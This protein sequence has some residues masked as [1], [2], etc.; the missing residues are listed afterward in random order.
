VSISAPEIKTNNFLLPGFYFRKRQICFNAFSRSYS[1]LQYLMLY[2]SVY[3]NNLKG[4]NIISTLSRDQVIKIN[5]K[6]LLLY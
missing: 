3:S 4:R 5:I 6:L 2:F 1:F